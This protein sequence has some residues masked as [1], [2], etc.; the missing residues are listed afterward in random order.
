MTQHQERDVR[1]EQILTAA[2]RLFSARGYENTA[3]DEIAREAGLSKGSIYWYFKSKLDILF[4]ITDRVV[5]EGQERLV[6]LADLGRMGPEALYKSHRE[7]SLLDHGGPERAEV[8]S[9]LTALAA[10]YPEIRERLA[11]YHRTWSEVTAQLLER[12]AEQGHFRRANMTQ[13]AQ[14]IVALY[15]G[16]H[17]HQQLDPEIDCMA[18]IETATRLIYDALVMRNDETPS[19]EEHA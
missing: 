7:L 19:S 12:A 4:S 10:Q 2:M 1:R 15:E 9:Q 14:A 17:V 16:V 18:V 13:V 8:Y 5:S 6:D 3:V 11:T